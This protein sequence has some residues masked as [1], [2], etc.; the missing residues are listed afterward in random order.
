MGGCEQWEGRQPA[1][2]RPFCHFNVRENG[3]RFEVF[4]GVVASGFVF[5]LTFERSGDGWTL[6]SSERA[7]GT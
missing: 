6:A 3:D 1:E 5:K 7:T 4:V 2:E